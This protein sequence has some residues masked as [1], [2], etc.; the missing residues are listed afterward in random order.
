MADQP[1]H[2]GISL[3]CAPLNLASSTIIGYQE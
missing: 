1:N 2:S 3:L